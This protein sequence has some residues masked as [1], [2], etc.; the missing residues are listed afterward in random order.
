MN[1]LLLLALTL[2]LTSDAFACVCELVDASEEETVRHGFEQAV[3][4]AVMKVM[5]IDRRGAHSQEGPMAELAVVYSFKDSVDSPTQ[6]RAAGFFT[7]RSLVRSS[8][9]DTMLEV[10]D[11]VIAFVPTDGYVSFSMCS[12]LNSELDFGRLELLFQ[13]KRQLGALS[14][15]GA[16]GNLAADLRR[17]P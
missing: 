12:N 11:M 10:G 2:I 14:E 16:G 5:S 7:K 15:N 4:V 17:I 1:R 3:A 8:C 13:L 9:A 6:V